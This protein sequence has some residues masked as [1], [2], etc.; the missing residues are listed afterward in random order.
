[1]T[2][3][4]YQPDPLSLTPWTSINVEVFSPFCNL[5][6]AFLLAITVMFPNS[7]TNTISKLFQSP[8]VDVVL[9]NTIEVIFSMLFSSTF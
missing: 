5:V 6:E 9:N 4:I 2:M 1:M 8:N 7:Y 3:Y